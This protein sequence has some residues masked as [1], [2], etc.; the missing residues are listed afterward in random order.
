MITNAYNAFIYLLFVT[1][2]L[3]EA[4]LRLSSAPIKCAIMAI[5]DFDRD[6]VSNVIL[7]LTNKYLN[8]RLSM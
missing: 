1:Q 7:L 4:S 3:V 5:N 6:F 2:G 8:N